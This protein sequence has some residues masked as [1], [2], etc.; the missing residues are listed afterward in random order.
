MGTVTSPY[1]CRVRTTI[2][3]EQEVNYENIKENL[4]KRLYYSAKADKRRSR[5]VSGQCC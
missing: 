1:E 5:I 4:Q 3:I 2:H